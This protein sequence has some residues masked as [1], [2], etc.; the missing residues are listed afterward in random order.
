MNEI[1]VGTMRNFPLGLGTR[2]GSCLSCLLFNILLEILAKQIRK[3]NKRYTDWGG[4]HKTVS[5][6]K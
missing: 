5:T 3:G 4:R 6:H 1:L 2:Q